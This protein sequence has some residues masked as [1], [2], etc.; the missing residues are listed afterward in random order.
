[1]AQ[2]FLNQGLSVSSQGVGS[3][4]VQ[5]AFLT[6]QVIRLAQHLKTHSK[7]Y[8]SQ[9]GLRKILGKRKRLLG[10]L[11]RENAARYE[12]LLAQLSIRGLNKNN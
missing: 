5:I 8:S 4:E 7:D 10:Y 9:R 3:S 11:G 12:S 1:M 6:K 2:H